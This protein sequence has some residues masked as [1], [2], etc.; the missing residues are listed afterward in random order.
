MVAGGRL[1]IRLLGA[2]TL[3]PARQE[4]DRHW[5]EVCP[6]SALAGD[7]QASSASS[8]GFRGPGAHRLPPLPLG[9][10]HNVAAGAAGEGPRARPFP[11]TRKPHASLPHPFRTGLDTGV[12]EP[13]QTQEEGTGTPSLDESRVH[14]L[15]PQ[16]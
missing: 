14:G 8:P 2:Q 11:L 6:H 4:G 13:H 9:P 12:R 3:A 16:P 5:G 7:P 1:M 10:P 15:K